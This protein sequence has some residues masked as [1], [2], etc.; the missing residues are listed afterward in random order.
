M[1][2]IE[3]LATGVSLTATGLMSAG[4]TRLVK[5]SMVLWLFGS[6]LWFTVGYQNN[7]LGLMIVNTGFFVLESWGLYKWFKVG[8]SK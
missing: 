4:K 7:V 3:L 1:G 6:V 8:G 5:Y 2:L